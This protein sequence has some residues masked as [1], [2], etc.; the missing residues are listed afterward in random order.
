MT[1]VLT[2][3]Y[4]PSTESDV[5][6]KEKKMEKEKTGPCYFCNSEV[7]DFYFC[8]ECKEYV[9]SLC[10]INKPLGYHSPNKHQDKNFED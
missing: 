2:K 10:D 5:G 8:F 3:P 1:I 6:Y 9:C 4:N 7:S